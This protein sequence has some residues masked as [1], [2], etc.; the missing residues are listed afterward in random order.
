MYKIILVLIIMAAFSIPSPSN[1]DTIYSWK[2]KNGNLKF[3]NSPPPEN[4]T[5]YQKTVSDVSEADEQTTGNKRRPKFDEMVERASR[6]ADAS[7]REREERAAAEAAERKRIAEAKR[8]AEAQAERERLEK[9][10]EAIRN[11]AVSPTYSNGMKQAQIDELTKKIEAL[12]G[13]TAPAAKKA[14]DADEKTEKFSN[15]Y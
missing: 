13:S 11:R 6:E 1:A 5:E 15:K 4:I 14:K 2:D 7:R 3:S 8:R 12:G 10:I 9:Q